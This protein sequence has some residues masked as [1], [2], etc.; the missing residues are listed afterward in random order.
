[1]A[2]SVQQL[3][4]LIQ[5]QVVGEASRVIDGARPVQEAG[6][7]HVTFIEN[8]H[9][10]RDLKDSK[11][12]A[13]VLPA[14]LSGKYAPFLAGQA[15]PLS[16]ILVKDALGAFI[17]LVQHLQGEAPRP[18]HGIDPAAW[19]HPSVQVG[20]APSIFPFASIGEGTRIGARCQ[21]HSGVRIGRHCRLGD[22]VILYPNVVLY[23]NT[24]LGQRV[25]VHGNAVIG[26]DGF[27]YRFQEGRHVKVPQFGSVELGDDVEIGACTTVDRG[28]FQVTR[29]GGGTKID[30]LVM[31]GHNCQ[32]GRHN[33]LVSQVGIAGSCT[34]GDYV[35]MAGQ[36][37]LADHIHVGDRAQIGAQAGVMR[38]VPPGERHLGAP[39]RSEREQKRIFLC[40]ERLPE[41]CRDVKA[42]KR[43][44]GMNDEKAQQDR[45]AE[46]AA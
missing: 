31:I 10:L 35:V 26:A 7:S 22:D 41:V 25:I 34:T 46:P 2:N 45:P 3:A 21:I 43:Q 4:A 42:I 40:M 19:V 16:V 33:M 39:A 23:D 11:A 44:L 32:I 1:V 15:M 18:P 30:N 38:D 8:E 13:V 12:G 14:A 6:P 27:G 37:G 28:T 5:G 20:A 9:H 36:V 29:I 24:V 17:T